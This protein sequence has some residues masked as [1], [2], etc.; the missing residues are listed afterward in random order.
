[1]RVKLKHCV[2]LLGLAALWVMGPAAP[3]A[4]AADAS[5]EGASADGSVALFSTT[6]KLVPGDTDSFRDVYD[7]SFDFGVDAYV[8]REISTGP[9][10]GNDA[11]HALYRV[12]SADGRKVFF[13]TQEPL[14]AADLDRSVDVYRHD[15][16]TGTM[17]V[18]AA[19]ASCSAGPCGNGPADATFKGT[20]PD[21]KKAF[22]E[23]SESLA[24][25]DGDEASDVYMRDMASEPP[26]TILISQADPSCTAG[27][28]GDGPEA[29]T[30]VGASESG[31]RVFIETS[32]SLSSADGDSSNDIYMR[33]LTGGPAATTPLS[34]GGSCPGLQASACSPKFRGASTDGSRVFFTSS[35]QFGGGDT[36]KGSDVY[37]WEAGT[38]SLL[39]IGAVGGNGEEKPATF[40]GATASGAAV[41]FETNENLTDADKDSAG[42]VY[43]RD[44]TSDV[45][46]TALVSQ[47]DPACV[48][49]TACGKGLLNTSFAGVSADGDTVFM[50]T[51]ETLV[52]ADTDGVNDIYARDLGG[53]TTSLVSVPA[54]ACEGGACG[55][56]AAA[57]FA[58][59][60]SSGSAKALFSTVESLVA[61][62]QDQAKDV[63]MRDLGT[64]STT[65]ESPAGICPLP[66]EKGCDATFAGAS[67]DLTHV[68]FRTEERLT[69]EDIDSD[70]DVYER[71]DGATRLV[72]ASNSVELGPATPVLT[73]TSPAS[74]GASLTPS[75]LGQ[76]DANSSIKLYTSSDCSGAAV[77]GT[78]AQLEGAGI[79][80]TVAA[81]STT[82]FR[83]TATDVN[84]DTSGC[85]NAVTYRQENP[86]PPP[87]EGEGGGGGS[88]QSPAPSPSPTPAPAP[89]PV[90]THDG[91]A[92]V[93]PATR[94]TFGPA[95]KTRARNP[96]FRFTDSTGQPGTSFVCR[97]DRH[98]WKP[99][100]SPVRLKNLN[101]GKHV[102]QVKGR[103]A[104]GVWETRPAKRAV[105]LVGGRR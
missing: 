100:E 51:D 104:I 99:C 12:S 53:G 94:I 8:T 96:V 78:V 71:A 30:F 75:I 41:F 11:Y 64:A 1:M 49:L 20:T 73:A 47:A 38:A 65:L 17:L 15:L 26:A 61:S 55:A 42:D 67:A 7:R 79:P 29:E 86:A 97:V 80:V 32:E 16:A 27:A 28:C 58:A 92:Y 66:E 21:G 60:S 36:D 74:P 33:D 95:F 105:K 81:S 88:G 14:V 3:A 24:L 90:P 68:F 37:A 91:I 9:T 52:P 93:T 19:A 76:A 54:P 39:S 43:V 22:F 72:S 57:T 87:G 34:A 23:T 6:D 103:N 56:A 77:A 70:L 40:A 10:G 45:S 83:A 102:F 89:V 44:P 69:A 84:G 5:F 101:R 46:A 63:Y 98:R 25:A 48:D 31:G 4:S 18:S 85:S 82:S 50:Q 13:S 62:D 35:E 2:V 59:V